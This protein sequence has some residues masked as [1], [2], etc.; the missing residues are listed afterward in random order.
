MYTYICINYMYKKQNRTEKKTYMH[1]SYSLLIYTQSEYT[2][3][4]SIMHTYMCILV[5]RYLK[6]TILTDV[7]LYEFG[8]VGNVGRNVDQVIL[9]QCQLTEIGQSEEFLK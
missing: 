2:C 1:A 3:T 7:K 8:E 9:T 4:A 6:L 5:G